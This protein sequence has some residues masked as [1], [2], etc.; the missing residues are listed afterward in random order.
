MLDPDKNQKWP[1]FVQIRFE[2]DSGERSEWCIAKVHHHSGTLQFEINGGL[3]AAERLFCEELMGEAGL[4][5]KNGKSATESSVTLSPNP[6]IHN[7]EFNDSR[8][9][10]KLRRAV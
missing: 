8:Y 1:K 2:L 7:T 4:I 5:Q 3:Y 10:M 9:W 6:E